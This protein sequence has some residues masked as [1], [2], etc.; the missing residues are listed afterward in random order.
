[1]VAMEWELLKK[2]V[3]LAWCSNGYGCTYIA[4]WWWWGDRGSRPEPGN[5]VEISS[6]IGSMSI[7]SVDPK[8]SE[9]YMDWGYQ[10]LISNIYLHVND[11]TTCCTSMKIC[12]LIRQLISI[13][14]SSISME[15]PHKHWA[16]MHGIGGDPGNSAAWT[17]PAQ[18]CAARIGSRNAIVGPWACC[19]CSPINTK[20]T[21]CWLMWLCNGQWLIVDG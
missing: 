19:R 20:Q 17:N 13:S 6:D 7:G 14:M 18:P 9:F 10:Q 4:G 12:E 16:A 15:E 1:M 8:E 2:W 3:R 5:C 11:G 21:C